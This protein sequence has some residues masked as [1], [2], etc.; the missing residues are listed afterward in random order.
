MATTQEAKNR[1]TLPSI[2]SKEEKAI[3]PA[4]RAVLFTQEPEGGS[5]LSALADDKMLFVCMH[6]QHIA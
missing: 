5:S 2:W 4:F 3:S 6:A 1:T